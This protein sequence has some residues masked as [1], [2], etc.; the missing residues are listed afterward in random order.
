MSAAVALMVATGRLGP[1]LLFLALLGVGTLWLG[2]VIDWIYLRW[3]MAFVADLALVV[4]CSARPARAARR[5]RARR[6]SSPS[7]CSPVPGQHRRA[8]AA[9]PAAVVDFEV[10]QT[11]VLIAVGLGGAAYLGV[12][13]AWAG[14]RVGIVSLTSGCH[15]RHGVRVRRAPP[16][17]KANFCFYG[18]VALA[19]ALAGT[20]LLLGGA[21]LSITWAVLAI[22]ACTI[23]RPMNRYTLA[24]H[25]C[26]FAAA[27]AYQSGAFA[28]ATT[29]VLSSVAVAWPRP[30]SA[31]PA[32]VAA[33]ATA[34][35][36][37]RALSGHPLQTAQRIPRCATI[38]ALAIAA[39][40]LVLG[41][42]VPL[43][44]G[45]PGPT[46]SAGVAA[47]VRTAVLVGGTLLL[48]WAG[49]REAWR[50]AGWLAYPVLVLTGL[51]LV[52][53]D[54]SRSPPATLFVAFGLYG[55]ALILVPRL[56]RKE[57]RRATPTPSVTPAT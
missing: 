24:M 33:L 26:V 54:I 46:A 31:V 37:T 30:S 6:S 34:A 4:S 8:D 23:A 38:A 45:T 48:A 20:G 10:V 56:R 1:P 47:T 29:A 53:E 28:H 52:L 3:P 55:A 9:P 42:T 16:A 13:R 5:G 7:S 25:G 21:T 19:F 35:W 18:T 43:L 11:A 15:V 36:E 2:Y 41:W 32:V 17:G 12:S 57:A 50:E 44:A 14:R 27:G 40:G 22:S 39:S 49:T 51:K